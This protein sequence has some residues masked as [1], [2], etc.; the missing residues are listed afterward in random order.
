MER[1]EL[2]RGGPPD[3]GAAEMHARAERRLYALGLASMI[4]ASFF[5]SLAG[6]LVRL[7]ED[8]QGFTLLFYRSLAFV[9]FMALF[10]GLRYR[11]RTLSA[12]RDIGRPGVIVTLALGVAFMSYIFALIETSVARVV[13]I[14]GTTPFVAAA[15]AWLVLRERLEPK[16][17]LAMLGALVGIGIMV[18]EGMAEGSMLG[19]VLAFIPVLGYAVTLVCFRFNKGVDMLPAGMLAGIVALAV[20]AIAAPTLAISANDLLMA[21]LLGVVQ[22][23]FQYVLVTYGVRHVSAGEAALLGR[24]QLVLAPIWVWVGVGEVPSL[25][26]LFGGGVILSVVLL[27]SLVMLRSGK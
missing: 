2:E 20:S 13:F 27:H 9:L 21:V 6:I 23:G 3:D 1:P 15:L 17:L 10:L 5:T 12:F 7:V 11:G 14:G 18:G 19:L 16:T 4:C 22:L 24:M 25:A 26:T 8:A